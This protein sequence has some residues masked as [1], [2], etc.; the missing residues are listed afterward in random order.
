MT[1]I[2]VTGQ[3]GHQFPYIYYLCYEL[4]LT[5]TLVF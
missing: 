4:H 5:D 3:N 1:V 2:V